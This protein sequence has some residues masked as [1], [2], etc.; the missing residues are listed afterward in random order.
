MWK[1][2][3]RN[4]GYL[5]IAFSHYQTGSL[6]KFSLSRSFFNSQAVKVRSVEKKDWT[7]IEKICQKN[8]PTLYSDKQITMYRTQTTVRRSRSHY[9]NVEK[10]LSSLSRP[11]TMSFSQWNSLDLST[12]CTHVLRWAKG[13]S[14]T[15]FSTRLLVLIKH[16][17][18]NCKCI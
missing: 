18:A 13:V 4:R 3:S 5:Q 12:C 14:Q 9:R 10:T 17:L 7:L 2:L 15:T 16:C 1:I 11:D 6:T 8:P